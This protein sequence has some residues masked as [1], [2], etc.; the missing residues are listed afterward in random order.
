MASEIQKY[1]VINQRKEEELINMQQDLNAKTHTSHALKQE[2]EELIYEIKNF[3]D[4]RHHV[5][6]ENMKSNQSY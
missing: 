1:K 3:K 4:E 2:L 5:K 6:N